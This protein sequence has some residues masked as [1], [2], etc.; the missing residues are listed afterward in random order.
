MRLLWLLLLIPLLPAAGAVYQWVGWRRDRARF[1][2]LG[3]LVDIAGGRRI[4][5][6]QA[7]STG[8]SIVFESGIAATSQNWTALQNDVSR[9]ARTLSYDRGGLGWSDPAALSPVPSHL[10]PELRMVLQR[11]G[12]P[13]PYILVGHSFGCMIVRRFALD[14]PDEVAALI[15]VDSMRTED[16]PPVNPAKQALLDRGIKLAG[17]AVPIARFGVARLATTSQLCR[18]GK[19][20]RLLSGAAGGGGLHVLERITCEVSKMPRAV[21][22]IIAAHWSSPAFYGGLAAHISAVPETVRE[23][24]SLPPIPGIPLVILTAGNAVPLCD[25]ELLRIGPGARQ[26]VAADSGHWVH[27]DRHDLVLQCIREIVEG[28]RPCD[29]SGELVGAHAGDAPDA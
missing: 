19:T 14:Y 25:D 7:G 17:M 11:A 26:I 8:P 29:D 6:T 24:L 12:M 9:F 15:L 13:P 5:V 22:P 18:S 27:L 3:R 23:T 2:P 10:A 21:W 1:L 28:L 16:W 4:F 20:S